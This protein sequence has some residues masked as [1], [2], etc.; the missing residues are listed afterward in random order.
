MTDFRKDRKFND[1]RR[2][3]LHVFMARRSKG[4]QGA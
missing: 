4:G 3:G 2:N 1:S